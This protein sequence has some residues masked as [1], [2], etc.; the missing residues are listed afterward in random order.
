M[1]VGLPRP[2][3][4]GGRQLS[5]LLVAWLSRCYT[6]NVGLLNHW[7][8]QYLAIVWVW[9]TRVAACEFKRWFG[10]CR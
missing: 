5:L 10:F 7:S 6:C 2:T 9:S 1:I 4:D 3:G 8:M